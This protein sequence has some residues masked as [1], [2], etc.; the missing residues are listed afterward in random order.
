PSGVRLLRGAQTLPP[1]G[2]VPLPDEVAPQLCAHL[3]PGE[4]LFLHTDG[5]EDAR[6]RRGRCFPLDRALARAAGTAAT[7]AR[8]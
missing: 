4:G 1:L 2:V 7:P 8:L 5:V 3:A 6:D